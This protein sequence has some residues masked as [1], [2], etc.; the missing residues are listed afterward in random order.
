MHFQILVMIREKKG[1]QTMKKILVRAG[2]NPW[3]LYTPDEVLS[4]NL[5]GNNSGNLIYA[6]GIF[7]ALESKKV[8]LEADYYQAGPEKAEKINR[9][10]GAYV[11][12]LADGFRK[13]FIPHLVQMTKL[14]KKL[15][16]PCIV[17]GVGLRAPYEPDIKEKRPFDKEVKAFVKAVLNHSSMIGVRGEI[18][19]AYLKQL[20]FREEMDYRVIGCPSM[21]AR[22]MGVEVK[23]PVLTEKSKINVNY[24]V[25]SPPEVIRFLNRVLQERENAWLTTQ[26]INELKLLYLGTS[27]QHQQ[28]KPE[29]P[30]N[31]CDSV[32]QRNQVRFFINAVQWIENMKEMDFSIGGR[33]HGNIAAW[34]SGTPALFLP[35]DG[36]M[37]ELVE[38]HRLPSVP[39][40]EAGQL[41]SLEEAIE[42]ADWRSAKLCQELNFRRYLDFLT[43]NGLETNL[44]EKP[45]PINPW[46]NKLQENNEKNGTS[47][48]QD[49]HQIV[50]PLEMVQGVES[51]VKL[52]SLAETAERWENYEVV[53]LANKN[54][55]I[56]ELR[57][58]VQLYEPSSLKKHI[59]GLVLKAFQKR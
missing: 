5:I 28:D 4:R 54:K 40:Q 9:E 20:G 33:M 31:I 18:T 3:D 38:F 8:S 12:P 23:K 43:M 51:I 56:R 47:R 49:N 7:Q 45:S 22:G 30:T 15:T 17:P 36:R 21:Y 34:I 52:P 2:M 19:G 46:K 6:Y 10:Y 24:S 16:I 53:S 58:H 50:S 27:Y 55:T 14:I 59:C 48:S 11:I 41:E 44:G 39:G 1:R 26:R 25:L 13:D 29:Y 35:H 32:Y 37:R 42:K 57:R